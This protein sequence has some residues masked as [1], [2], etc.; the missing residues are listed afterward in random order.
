MRNSFEEKALSSVKK[1]K[2]RRPLAASVPVET[3]PLNL[4]W[5]II[6]GVWLLLTVS[7]YLAYSNSFD[8]RLFFDDLSSVIGNPH[9]QVFSNP[10]TRWTWEGWKNALG[11]EID[12]PFAGRP[13]V[14]LTFAL[15]HWWAFTWHK[16]EIPEFYGVLPPHH[17]FYHAV[18][19]GFHVAVAILLW[20][21]LRR[22]FRAPNVAQYTGKHADLWATAIS[23][24]WTVH[25]LNT[26]TVVYVT[27]R[28][29][30]V[31]SFFLLLTIYSSSRAIDARS[32]FSRIA[33]Q[34][35]SFLACCLGMASK[36]NMVGV[37]LLVILYD[38]A[39]Y[40]STWREIF[41]KRLWFYTAIFTTYTLLIYIN[42]ATFG[43]ITP[44]EPPKQV[45]PPSMQTVQPG[46]K[47]PT[48]ETESDKT[49]HWKPAW[50]IALSHT[51]RLLGLLSL[52]VFF[53]RMLYY[54]DLRTLFCER[55][56]YY[57]FAL[58]GIA[59][60][61]IA[62]ETLSRT[63]LWGAR[64][65][66]EATVHGAP[67]PV[68]T[69]P[70][71]STYT[72]ASK[73]VAAAVGKTLRMQW[74]ADLVEFLMLKGPFLVLLSLVIVGAEKWS[75]ATWAVVRSRAMYYVALIGLFMCL[76]VRAEVGPRGMSVGFGFE[77]MDWLE[78]LITQN[79][80]LLRY[81]RLC[82]IPTGLC[83]D[84][85]RLAILDLPDVVP[86]AIVVL[87]LL[88]L[89]V[90]GWIY[91]PWVGFI[92]AWFFFILAPT[93]SF[94]P[95]V[96]EVGAER[97]MYLPLAAVL[98]AIGVALAALIRKLRGK[99]STAEEATPETE[100]KQSLGTIGTVFCWA[101]LV[102]VVLI[103]GFMSYQRN[104]DY[105]TESTL[106]GHIPKVFP[107]NERG[108]NNYAKI[109]IDE[110]RIEEAEYWLN[111]ALEIDPEY[112]DAFTN[113]GI[114][115]HRRKQMDRAIQNA[116]DALRWNPMNPSA[117]NNRGNAF[118]ELKLFH[119]AVAD[120]TRLTEINPRGVEGYYGRANT[121]YLSG[122]PRKA[123]SDIDQVILRSP[124]DYKAYNTRGNILK[125]LGEYERAIEAFSTGVDLVFK[126]AASARNPC[127]PALKLA[128]EGKINEPL[129]INGQTATVHQVVL[130]FY[131]RTT[132]ATILGNRAD[133][134]RN[135]IAKFPSAKQNM[136]D[137]LTR[138]I[139]LHT[140]NP[141]YFLA[142]AQQNFENKAF[143][144]AFSDF[145]EVLKIQP[146][147]VDGLRGRI[148]SA[149]E[150]KNWDI[151]KQDVKML[152]ELGAPVDAP[153]L[154]KFKELSGRDDIQ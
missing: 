130:Q 62:Q 108:C 43:V 75:G 112:S 98:V 38:R 7:A 57:A 24:I 3:R 36:E 82:I 92:G 47:L 128:M 135:L 93:S 32:T 67:P 116:T 28:T 144:Q 18:N 129:N 11:A 12:T 79:W 143:P 20:H 80:C 76:Y 97:R 39:F 91:K 26:E 154:A 109:C 59:V 101:V 115:Y 6:P 150:L 5:L 85:G 104:K 60:L 52:M 68:S 113:R 27:Q 46:A 141:M 2:P 19:F 77:R 70:N 41:Q 119:K 139:I 122:E 145:N 88:A 142:R 120:F 8:G 61:L 49:L 40:F 42:A 126:E 35:T 58:G 152:R 21:F 17:W 48:P 72:D 4:K 73:T 153:T 103:Y 151:V 100:P 74:P 15:N 44:P 31:L 96:T 65:P 118:I 51:A 83:V 71:W 30:Q 146:N 56:R 131:N 99:L 66:V 148:L 110:N 133:A 138:A 134:Y 34:V 140:E 137:D 16:A 89:T 78:Y 54:L 22:T 1:P 123:L 127:V 124:G 147:A 25:P 29:E 69:K 107:W 23:L 102:W 53:D 9:L 121:Y 37:P 50:R 81:L 87:S 149:V 86:G 125:Q 45:A 84:Y 33:W 132:L 105:L 111:N 95:I 13:I 14:S 90:W 10:K 55:W 63:A 94:I 136:F 114:I 64:L 106:Y 117:W